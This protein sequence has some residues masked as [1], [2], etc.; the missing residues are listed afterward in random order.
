MSDNTD[1]IADLVSAPVN[2]A[3][4][5]EQRTPIVPLYTDPDRVTPAHTVKNEQPWHRSLA[6]ALLQGKTSRECAELFQVTPATVSLVKR[7]SWFK[8]LI[9]E[10][11]A[12]HF[13]ND[14]TG[15]LATHA[16]DAI[17]QLGE[18]SMSAESP[19][20]R[21]QASSDLLKAYLS[22]KPEKQAPKAEDPQSELAELDRELK[23]LS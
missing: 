3:P 23:E 8:D 1:W 14:F 10:L 20:I 13:E 15:L 4:V 11:G 21:R 22:C 7:Q 12:I 16:I 18:L 19:Q 9:A 17:T 5:I 2:D 6:Y